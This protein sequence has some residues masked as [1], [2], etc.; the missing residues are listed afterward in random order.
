QLDQRDKLREIPLHKAARR[1]NAR[2]VQALCAAR[3]KVNLRNRSRETPLL[4]A[5]AAR[6]SECAAILLSHG[7][8]VDEPDSSG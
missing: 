3:M 6:S 8:T 2:I 5:V 4:L 7:A 1:G